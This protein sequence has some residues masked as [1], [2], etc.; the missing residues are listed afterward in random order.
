VRA[1]YPGTQACK[2]LRSEC[3][4]VVLANSNPATIM[5]DPAGSSS[6]NRL[7]VG[8]LRVGG[9]CGCLPIGITTR[10]TKVNQNAGA[11]V[12]SRSA[13]VRVLVSIDT[14]GALAGQ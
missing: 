1:R 11:L 3:C 6:V 9:V 12:Y 7:V 5:T 10:P 4:E 8:Y 2:A 14:N 13:N